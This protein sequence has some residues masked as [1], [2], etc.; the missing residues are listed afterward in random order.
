[1]WSSKLY[2]ILLIYKENDAEVFAGRQ[3]KHDGYALLIFVT[4][5]F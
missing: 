4:V 2:N 3:E 5:Y 1:V